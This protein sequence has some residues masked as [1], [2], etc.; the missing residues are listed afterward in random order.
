[1]R[2]LQ[3]INHFPGMHAIC[4]KD[5]LARSL[6][7]MQARA[8][9]RGACSSFPPPV[10]IQNTCSTFPVIMLWSGGAGGIGKHGQNLQRLRMEPF[11]FFC[12]VSLAC[13]SIQPPLFLSAPLPVGV[14]SFLRFPACSSVFM[15]SAR[16]AGGVCVF[17]EDLGPPF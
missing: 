16:A 2:G 5:H 10:N 4:Q 6:S 7:R 9:G 1:M 15:N 11:L 3:K 12:H 13:C 8:S 17:A 14:P